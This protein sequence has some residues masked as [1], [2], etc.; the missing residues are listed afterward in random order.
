MSPL[1]ISIS[2]KISPEESGADDLDSVAASSQGASTTPS[3]SLVLHSTSDLC[4]GTR[5]HAYLLL[6]STNVVPKSVVL[7]A[8]LHSGERFSLDIPVAERVTNKGSYPL[9]HPLV[10]QKLIQ[11]LNSSDPGARAMSM[12]LAKA[13]NILSDATSFICVDESGVQQMEMK[14]RW[15]PPSSP[16]PDGSWSWSWREGHKSKLATI[17]KIQTC[18]Y[19]SPSKLSTFHYRTASKLRRFISILSFTLVPSREY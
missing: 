16:R 2:L 4:H 8:Q 14:T 17:P 19:S 5:F 18:H 15:I 3:G 7:N 13:H 9:I 6:T 1:P 10:A 11:D 12:K